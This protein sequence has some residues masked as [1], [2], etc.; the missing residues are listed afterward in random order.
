MNEINKGYCC[1]NNINFEIP[2]VDGK[3]DLT[4]ES[5]NFT[6]KEIEVFILNEA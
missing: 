4:E 6:A 3:S 2:Y 5:K 1:D